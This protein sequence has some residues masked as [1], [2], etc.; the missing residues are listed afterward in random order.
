MRGQSSIEFM[1]AV[2]LL[3]AIF[4]VLTPVAYIKYT[5]NLNAQL[6]TDAQ[7]VADTVAGEINTAAG[8]GTGYRRAF[9][10]PPLLGDSRPYTVTIYAAE[11]QV[12]VNW[13]DSTAVSSAIA[14]SN[15]TQTSPLDPGENIVFNNGGLIEVG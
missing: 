3:L 8:V 15:V 9:I 1:Q 5:D 13:T 11:Q 2:G 6:R 7:L 10:L 12:Y 14:T 4:I